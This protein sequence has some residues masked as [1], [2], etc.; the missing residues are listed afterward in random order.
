[1]SQ[2]L[3]SKKMG[4]VGA[5]E[6]RVRAEQQGMRVDPWGLRS[7]GKIFGILIEGDRKTLREEFC[8]WA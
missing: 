5:G 3:K 1:M 2:H 7:P 4:R 6:E 8:A